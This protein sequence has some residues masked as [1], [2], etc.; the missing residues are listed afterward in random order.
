MS[1]NY[2]NG[3][4][5]VAHCGNLTCTTGTTL[6]VV[7][8]LVRAMSNSSI[9]IGTDGLPVVSYFDLTTD[10]LKVAHCGN[11][12]CTA[13]NT[14][15]TVD[16]VGS[17][18]SGASIAIG[19]DGLP[20]MSYRDSTI[21]GLKVAHCGNVTCTAGNTLTR[22]GAGHTSAIAIGAD[23]LPVVSYIDSTNG[24]LTVAHCGTVTCAAGHTLTAVEFVGAGEDTS[25]AI[26]TDGLPVVS[27]QDGTSN[28]A[29]K[30][31]HCGDPVSCT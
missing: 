8:S 2:P 17:V 22:V 15:T 16:S 31:A 12:T 18:G 1:Y 3:D 10:D 13:G 28:G 14:L 21:N 5:K 23:G 24:A 7:D 25:I 20:V 6:T 27:Y 29:L 30:V 4:L 26:G 11:V 9:V 19:A